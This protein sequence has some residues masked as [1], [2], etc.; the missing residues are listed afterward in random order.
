MAKI[1]NPQDQFGKDLATVEGVNNRLIPLEKSFDLIKS[2][3][4]YLLIDKIEGSSEDEPYQDISFSLNVHDDGGNILEY[5]HSLDGKL[6]GA[7]TA[8]SSLQE[9]K[10]SLE[11]EIEQAKIDVY[12]MDDVDVKT[13]V[14]EFIN[15]NKI[16]FAG[17]Y[18][19]VV[20]GDEDGEIIVYINEDN[21]LPVWDQTAAESYTI[22]PMYVYSPPA[23][24]NITGNTVCNYV[25]PTA[26]IK[27]ITFNYNIAEDIE[28]AFSLS[29]SNYIFNIS[30]KVNGVSKQIVSNGL[31]GFNLSTLFGENIPNTTTEIDETTA[32]GDE[33]YSVRFKGKILGLDVAPNGKTPGSLEIETFSVTINEKNLEEGA[34]TDIKLS[35]EHPIAAGFEADMPNIYMWTQANSDKVNFGAATFTPEITEYKYI[36]GLKY[37]APVT[38]NKITFETTCTNLATGSLKTNVIKSTASGLAVKSPTSSASLTN[39]TKCGSLDI[40]NTYT[41][42]PKKFTR[43]SLSIKVEAPT[44]PSPNGIETKTYTDTTIYTVY[45]ENGSSSDTVED[46]INETYRKTSSWGEWNS[47]KRLVDREAL[48]QN[49][50]LYHLNA[51]SGYIRAEK[52][53]GNDNSDRYV[54]DYRGTCSF[55]RVFKGTAESETN[56]FYIK[57]NNGTNIIGSESIELAVWRYNNTLNAWDD[58]EYIANKIQTTTNNGLAAAALNDGRIE[59]TLPQ[60]CATLISKGIRMEIR[61]KNTTQKLE[62]IE[63]TFVK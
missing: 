12:N 11:N 46:F 51:E 8:K 55:Y 49:S 19:N 14:G 25:S 6:I 21:S 13:S 18:V 47:E 48:V 58:T 59:C 24:S 63:I 4:N 37:V 53:N 43:N 16:K 35:F 36:S 38:N 44:P 32:I 27:P 3:I 26:G 45:G 39:T 28:K 29:K 62:K 1:N 54:T 60:G 57:V 33:E 41:F 15:L 31:N 40:S 20:S 10:T 56:K 34:I 30:Y 23:G 5:E 9:V 50:T 61:L 7:T 52:I 17:R 42:D 2:D 22:T